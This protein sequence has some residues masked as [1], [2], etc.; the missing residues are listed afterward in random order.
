[1]TEISPTSREQGIA[2]IEQVIDRLSSISARAMSDVQEDP[3][4]VYN[5]CG[6]MQLVL[7][8]AIL[9]LQ[10]HPSRTL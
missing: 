2:L 5:A 6:E 8:Q 4:E 9:L 7:Q 3:S 10:A 1:V